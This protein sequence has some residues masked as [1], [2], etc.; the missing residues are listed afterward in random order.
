MREQILLLGH[1]T[2]SMCSSREAP[3]A[4]LEVAVMGLL[5]LASGTS[6][7]S[8]FHLPPKNWCATQAMANAL[9]CVLLTIC[10]STLVTFWW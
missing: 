7:Q 5:P 3:R 4:Q 9:C 10:L 2:V 1:S 6:N 8:L